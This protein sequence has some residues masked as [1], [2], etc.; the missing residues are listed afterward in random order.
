MPEASAASSGS[1]GDAPQPT[2]PALATPAGAAAD[3]TLPPE[4]QP[5][6]QT[7]QQL[8]DEGHASDAGAE[9]AALVLP[10]SPPPL[11]DSRSSVVSPTAAGPGDDASGSA[12]EDAAEA[13][14]AASSTA[15]FATVDSQAAAHVASPDANAAEGTLAAA[16]A[17]IA[18]EAPADQD[19]HPDSEQEQPATDDGEGSEAGG[20]DSAIS[21]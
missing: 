4:Q 21:I 8:P 11:S 16:A 15:S 3:E 6:Q 17:E 2:L 13:H 19:A 20:A 9:A 7:Q 5:Q 14:A 10:L 1:I 12:F 18:A